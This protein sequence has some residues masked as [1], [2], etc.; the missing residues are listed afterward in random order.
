M[1]LD[2]TCCSLADEQPGMLFPMWLIRAE[3]ILAMDRFRPYEELMAADIIV[4]YDPIVHAN[5]A[6]MFISHQW[7]SFTH[8][9]PSCE[10]LLTLQGCLERMRRRDFPS[11]SATFAD[12]LVL[13]DLKGLVMDEVDWPRIV[14]SG[15]VWLDFSCIPQHFALDRDPVFSRES[16]KSDLNE[17]S[18]ATLAAQD[19][20]R[21]AV[22]SIPA[23]V[24]ASTH[25]IVLCPPLK[26][27]DT[28]ETC[29]LSSWSGRGWCRLEIQALT[30]QANKKP[31]IVLRSPEAVP[32]M[33]PMAYTIAPVG[34]GTFKCCQRNHS[35]MLPNGTSQ[36]IPC[37]KP[38]IAEVVLK[39]LDART[40]RHMAR[41]ETDSTKMWLSLRSFYLAGLP[42][43]VWRINP[44]DVGLTPE[45][46]L[47]RERSH[48]AAAFARQMPTWLEAPSTG[49]TGGGLP[50]TRMVSLY[51]SENSN[52][53]SRP[54]LKVKDSA[55]AASMSGRL[56]RFMRQLGFRSANDCGDDGKAMSPLMCAVMTSDAVL[57]SELIDIGANPNQAYAGPQLPIY[58]LSLHAGATA[59]HIATFQAAIG[60]RDT[61]EVLLRRGALPGVVTSRGASP[62]MFLAACCFDA[63]GGIRTFHEVCREVGVAID[64]DAPATVNSATALQLACFAGPPECVHA[65]LDIGASVTH[66]ND[67]GSSIFCN[68]C[69]NDRIDVAT[70]ARLYEAEQCA[71]GGN[72]ALWTCAPRNAAWMAVDLVCEALHKCRATS[73][74]LVTI[75]ANTRGS[76]PLHVAAMVG[77]PR[78]I[79]DFLIAK[80]AGPSLFVRNAVGHT[81]LDCARLFGPFPETEHALQVH[82]QIYSLH[83]RIREARSEQSIR[84]VRG[85]SLHIRDT[86]GRIED[87]AS[88]RRAAL[89][90][91][92][93]V[94]SCESSTQSKLSAHADQIS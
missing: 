60:E 85:L 25:F 4:R 7:T 70:L 52:A 74:A 58:F 71:H 56:R 3:D 86:D 43:E 13:G 18:A 84:R 75:V 54:C 41:G 6:I 20:L 51:A 10:Q 68:A 2:E 69:E 49:M 90:R 62:L 72:P 15:F 39:M 46:E 82:A 32:M 24:A 11:V 59:V 38:A 23:Y 57:V 48:L 50:A 63:G 83:T 36:L 64:V 37:D 47:S 34:H 9:D 8:P 88:W 87:S 35:R 92:S 42:I 93:P 31:A 33:L 78:Q 67:H 79:I 19:E 65:F 94:G 28:G 76:Q 22:H 21:R 73:A 12:K 91:A 55:G 45:D 89:S 30:L 40:R 14:E 5:E 44:W 61:L 80:G 1:G 27:L 53:A 17:V 29:N 77:Q 26:H 16:S 66:V 81:P